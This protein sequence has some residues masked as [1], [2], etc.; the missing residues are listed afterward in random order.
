MKALFSVGVSKKKRLKRTAILSHVNRLKV[1]TADWCV[2]VCFFIWFATT[3]WNICFHKIVSS[4][5]FS[6]IAFS[7]PY[8]KSNNRCGKKIFAPC[9]TI[10]FF[11]LDISSWRIERTSTSDTGFER[12]NIKSEILSYKF[13]GEKRGSSF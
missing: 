2:G 5:K 12:V 9:I 6:S 8:A 11:R 3:N 4:R 13:S 1:I 7:A 10:I